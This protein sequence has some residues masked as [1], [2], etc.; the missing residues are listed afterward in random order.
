MK[1]NNIL[2]AACLAALSLAACGGNKQENN[3]VALA[4]AGATFPEPYYTVAFDDYQAASANTVSYGGIGSGGGVRNL[5]DQIVDFAG[6]DAFLSDEEMKE[7]APVVHIPTCMGAVVLAYNLPEVE[8]LNLDAATVVGIFTGEITRWNDARIAALNPNASLPDKKVNPEYR[9]DGSGTTF[10]FTSY[11][12]SVSPSWAA[13]Y[14][15][16]KSVNFPTGQAAKGNPG[17]AGMIAQTEGAIGYVGSEYAFA[18][19]IPYAALQNQH[20]EMVE[21]NAESISLAASGDMPEDT[22]CMI[23]NSPAH[24]A[25]PISCFTWIVIYREQHYADRSLDQAKATLSLMRYMLSADAQN[26]TSEVN[27]APLPKKA[28]EQSIKNLATLTYD[29]APLS[30]L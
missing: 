9:S 10:I 4:G 21:A 25:Y 3:P 15:A 24:G 17:V 14:G 12:A 19:K 6:T 28:I 26:R 22:R 5:K 2:V 7:M 18:Q 16:A 29:G 1:K 30:T 20:G 27:Y 13:T 8:H 23:V 11:L